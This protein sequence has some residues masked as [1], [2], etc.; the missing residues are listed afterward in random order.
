MGVQNNNVILTYDK[1]YDKYKLFLIVI[2]MINI[3]TIDF[4]LKLKC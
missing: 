1:L 2:Y 3:F 4:L